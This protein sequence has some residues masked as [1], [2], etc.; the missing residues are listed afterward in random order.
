MVL[1]ARASVTQAD[2]DWTSPDWIA[3]LRSLLT[4]VKFLPVIGSDSNHACGVL[5]EALED[6]YVL[7]K[8]SAP[9]PEG[10]S[11]LFGRS[12]LDRTI[13]NDGF[14]SFLVKNRLVQEMSPDILL[15]FW[16]NNGAQSWWNTVA[17]GSMKLARNM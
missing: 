1:E 17:S 2:V 4:G 8:T 5:F 10:S 9:I 7:P 14:V 12:I 6:V 11:A 13:V 3:E 16:W 15:N